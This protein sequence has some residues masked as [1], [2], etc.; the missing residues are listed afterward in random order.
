MAPT[1]HLRAFQ[2]LELAVRTGSLTAAAEILGLTPAAVGQRIKG[3]EDYLGLDLILRSRSGILPTRG[4][5][6]A[7]PHLNAAFR[8]LGTVGDILDLHRAQEIHITADTDWADLWLIP[9]LPKFRT[10]FPNVL[11][12]V[13]GIGDVPIR[14]GKADCEVWF[15]PARNHPAEDRLFRD[16]LAPITSPD[17]VWRLG[18]RGRDKDLDGLPLLHI[19]RPARQESVFGWP[20]WIRMFG[21]RQTATERGI[22]YRHVHHAL[23]AVYSAAGILICGLALVRDDLLAGRI[24]LLFPMWEGQWTKDSYH[25]AFN[26]GAIRRGPVQ[27]F[28]KWLAAEAQA[29]EAGI[30]RLLT[31][32]RPVPG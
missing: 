12:C 3:L 10:D 11:F 6:A 18:G 31:T 26:E 30:E 7:L 23:E 24:T 15:G 2:A 17:N 27:Q 13:N 21:H 4:L 32:A 1:S 25:I 9:R 22:R 8:E 28:R 29:T 16:Y 14:L 5:E 19:E 20:E